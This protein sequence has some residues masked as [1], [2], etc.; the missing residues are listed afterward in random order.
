MVHV[1]TCCPIPWNAIQTA[2]DCRSE[3]SLKKRR[4]NKT[5]V[6]ADKLI[7]HGRFT[8][9]FGNIDFLSTCTY[10]CQSELKTGSRED[11]VRLDL[12]PFEI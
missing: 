6:R 9:I 12:H 7:Y 11:S 4:E 10:V 3:N 5:Y 1:I 8:C 2:V